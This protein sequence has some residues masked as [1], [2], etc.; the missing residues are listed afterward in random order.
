MTCLQAVD[1][2]PSGVVPVVHHMP[3]AVMGFAMVAHC[4]ASH[5]C[6][7]AALRHL[8]GECPCV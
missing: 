8:A 2:R 1:A 3:H 6:E 4:F 5:D 7:A